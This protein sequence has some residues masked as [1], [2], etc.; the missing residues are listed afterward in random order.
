MLKFWLLVV[1]LEEEQVLIQVEMKVVEVE[2][3]LFF[4]THQFQCLLEILP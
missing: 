2:Q 1:V 4:I 3:E